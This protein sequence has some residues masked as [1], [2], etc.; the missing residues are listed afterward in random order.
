MD[1]TFESQ[2][3]ALQAA[4]LDA[5]EARLVADFRRR[6]ARLAPRGAGRREAIVAFA[7]AA[8]AAAAIKLP[9]LWG[10]RMEDAEEFFARNLALFA[11]PPLVAYLA[12]KRAVTTRLQ[13]ALALAFVAALA[14]AN[15]APRLGDA[16]VR[17]TLHLPLA[18][19][20]A[21]GVAHAGGRWRETAAR[22]DFVRFSGEWFLHYVL[23]ALG[24]GVLTGCTLAM[25]ESIGLDAA[26]A[27]QR[28][29]LPCGAM[30]AV[31]VAAW[32]V[33]GRQGAMQGMATVLTRLF[34]PMFA[35]LLL[36][37]LFG[38]GWTGAGPEFHRDLLLAFDLLLALVVALVLFAIAGRDGARPPG[39]FD[40][41]LVVLVVAAL[42]VDAAALW[43]IA[44]RIGDY[45][46]TANRSA[47]L[48]ENL[49]LLA[50]LAGTAWLYP[51]YLR[52]R[53]TFARLESWQVRF[54]PLYSAWAALV[55]AVFP[56]VFG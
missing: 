16:D 55:V 23:I 5:E 18:L 40:G 47:V 34:A 37:F 25:F 56:F 4:G 54:L 35:L 43:A 39:V 29:I 8:A 17:V 26:P 51:R 36:G 12:W 27:F 28:W 7:L 52:G 41:V 22:M 31:T 9:E 24:G 33:E 14:F 38:M 2:Y 53:T 48:G 50:N 44:R 15:L 1:D 10:P 49:L 20:L 3:R 42:L 21:V 11:L 13:I 6:S 19:W 45:G 46:F 32:L 30:G